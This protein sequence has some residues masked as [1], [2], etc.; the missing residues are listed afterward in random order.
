M[1]H[2]LNWL[3][4]IP[5]LIAACSPQATVTPTT[6]PA[7]APVEATAE[8]TIAPISEATP[9]VDMTTYVDQRSGVAFDYPTGWTMVAPPDVE[10]DAYSYSVSSFEATDPSAAGGKTESGLPYGGTKIDITFYGTGETLDSAQRTV[11]TD[12]DS[13][14]AVVMKQEPRSMPDGSIAYYYQVNGRLGGTAQVIFASVNGR[15]VS[16]VAYGDGVH[17]EDVARSLRKA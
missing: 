7:A 9:S 11:Q 5:V 12:V 4:A 17:F 16:V 1:K 2:T 15:V 6:Q 13:G 10:S 8:A 14:M 3:L